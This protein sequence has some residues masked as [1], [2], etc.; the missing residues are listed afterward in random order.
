MTGAAA[1]VVVVL[2]VG[3]VACGLVAGAV[4]AFASLAAVGV[5]LLLVA[6][7]AVVAAV[8]AVVVDAVAFCGEEVTATGATLGLFSS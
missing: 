4:G 6:V 2:R 1:V 7:T 5:T 8:G 3:D